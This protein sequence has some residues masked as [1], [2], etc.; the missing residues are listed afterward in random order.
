MLNFF[1]REQLFEAWREKMSRMYGV[2]SPYVSGMANRLTPSTWNEY[3]RST[4]N[5]FLQTKQKR[6]FKLLSG[7]AGWLEKKTHCDQL[8]PSRVYNLP[9]AGFLALHGS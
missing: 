7:K 4:W 3:S 5:G 2:Y 9:L 6:Q 8:Y 1:Y